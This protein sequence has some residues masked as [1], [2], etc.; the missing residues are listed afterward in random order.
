MSFL[1]EEPQAPDGWGLLTTPPITRLDVSTLR[2]PNLARSNKR[3]S[4]RTP[5]GI[6]NIPLDNIVTS[7][8][9]WYS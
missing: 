7:P 3:Q 2:K 8:K 4:N 1:E 5:L 9:I 6:S